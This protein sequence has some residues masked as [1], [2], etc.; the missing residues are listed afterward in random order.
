MLVSAHIDFNVFL[1]FSSFIAQIETCRLK[2]ATEDLLLNLSPKINLSQYPLI[3]VDT[4]PTSV[5][6][7]NTEDF[8]TSS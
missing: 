2:S 1:D 4:A 5:K 7:K 3:K 6:V 8:F